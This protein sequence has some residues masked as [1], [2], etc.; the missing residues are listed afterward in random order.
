VVKLKGR[1]A[2]VTGGARGIGKAICLRMAEEGAKVVVADILDKEAQQTA[3]E[4]A[5]EGGEALAIKADIACDEDAQRLASESIKAFGRIDSLVNNAG[6]LYG[7]TRK[8]FMEIPLDEWERVM[9]VNVKGTFLCCRAVF[10]QMKKQ[11]KGK[12]I[13]ISSNS[14][15]GGPPNSIH[16]VISKIGVVALT[17]CLATEVAPYGICVNSVAPG[18]TDTEATRDFAEIKE[19]N[20]AQTPIGRLAQPEDIAGAVIFFASDES[21]YITAQTL[22]VD[23]GRRTH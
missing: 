15:F 5:A 12:I 16:Y 6:M 2:I 10:P 21:D 19:I 3:A 9:T 7:L 14:A 13:N 17:R 1:V 23:G 22:L 20:L 4:I 18:V 11:G 8:P